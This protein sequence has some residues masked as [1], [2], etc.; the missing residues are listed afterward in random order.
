MLIWINKDTG[1]LWRRLIRTAKAAPHIAM[2]RQR[3]SCRLLG[4]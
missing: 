4:P 3:S 2:A 1:R